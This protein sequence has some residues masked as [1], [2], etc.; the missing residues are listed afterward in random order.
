MQRNI[1]SLANN[2]FDLLI[3][4]GGIHGA[5]LLWQAA[6]AGLS[7]ALI[8]KKDFG[9]A[10]SANSQKIIHGGIR[11]LQS[12]DFARTRQSLRERRRLMHIA[13]HLVHP[14]PCLMPLY[15]HG[16][17]GK[18]AMSL[19]L[20]I[21]DL[22]GIDR[23]KDSDPSK[24]IPA[25]KI[26]ST[27]EICELIPGLQL[28][29]LKGGA[30]WYDA[31]CYNTER[32]VLAFIKSACRLGGVAHNYVK[33]KKILPRKDS[34]IIIKAHDKINDEDIDI[35]AKNVINCSGPWIFELLDSSSNESIRNQINY[36]V[37]I[38]IITKK[39]FPHDMAV[40]LKN[41]R[42]RKSRLYFVTPWRGKTIIG[43]E[44]FSNDTHPDQLIADENQCLKLID[45][46]N[47]AYQPANLTLA[48]I[49]YVHVGLVPCKKESASDRKNVN[50]L[51]HFRIIDHRKDGLDR[52]VS[53][54]GVKY[55]TAA[56]VAEN[57]LK[58]LFPNIKKTSTSSLPQ[59]AG[60][61]IENFSAL[62]TEMKNRWKSE[63]IDEDKLTQ[64]IFNYGREAGKIIEL[65]TTGKSDHSKDEN[66]IYNILRA[67]ILF[68]VRE[69]LAQKLSDVVLRRTELGT[70]GCPSES[71]LKEASIIMAEELDWDEAKRKSEINEVKDLYPPFLSSKNLKN[72]RVS[73]R[74]PHFQNCL[75]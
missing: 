74:A 7:V 26:V 53:P 39:I 44:W 46:L 10:T 60:G 35:L 27:S 41:H 2:K 72:Q 49:D 19:G 33:A 21:Y 22:I 52:V 25:G 40:G 67:Q 9:H 70:A 24:F 59:L 32:L 63:E 69:E 1:N 3:I 47:A 4:G 65:G 37:G 11:Y 30:K 15:G 36:A 71:S 66:S 23:N 75:Q 42:D 62:Q 73:E 5:V 58:Y 56:D 20:K 38:N 29:G 28:K 64:L 54:V 17:K 18:E 13:P 16:L 14:L 50:L 31:F 6:L 12:F 34:N 57:T 45:G 55:T 48:D 51:N 61:E 8:E 68:A 43:T